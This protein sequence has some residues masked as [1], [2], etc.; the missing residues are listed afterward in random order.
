MNSM[1]KTVALLLMLIG[2]SIAVS[3][4]K[5]PLLPE[6]QVK[7]LAQELSGETAKRN[8]EG[9]VRNHRQRGSKGFHA[10][11]ELVAERARAYG[12]SEVAILQFPA[13]GKTFYGPERSRP[14]WDADFAEL[15]ELRKEGDTWKPATLMASYEAI[16]VSLAEDSESADV[17]A[18]LI[19]VGNGTAD[20]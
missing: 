17:T 1:R 4:Q 16:P 7:A 13:D 19:D 11:A 12:L 20:S 9:I 18:D 8:L 14:P 2:F 3:G 15:W 5:P 10:A 6:D